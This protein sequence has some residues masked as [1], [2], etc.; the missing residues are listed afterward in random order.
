MGLPSIFRD[1]NA[2]A[3]LLFA[4]VL[5]FV[6]LDSIPLYTWDEARLAENAVEAAMDGHWFITH[7]EGKPDLWNT[8]PPLLIAVQAGLILV[9]G[10]TELAIR[11]PSA[12]AAV[13]LLF[14]VFRFVKA[15]SNSTV[16]AWLAAGMLCT[17]ALAMG[18]HNSRTGDY[19]ALL[20]LFLFLGAVRFY[21]YLNLERTTDLYISAL[22]FALAV[23]TKGIAGCLLFPSLAILLAI[24]GKL[25]QQLSKPS[26]Y[27]A[28]L[29]FLL[30]IA[31]Y[32][33]T[34][35]WAAPGYL[36][37]V[38]TNELGGRF[39][40]TLEGNEGSF[41]YYFEHLFNGRFGYW[42][43]FLLPSA[44][45]AL[46]KKP[47]DK[48]T[49]SGFLLALPFLLVISF[50][51]TKLEWY[52]LPALPFL[53]IS[54]SLILKEIID[55]ITR[56]NPAIPT[57]ALL[58]LLFTLPVQQVWNQNYRPR[59]SLGSEKEY[60]FS[61]SSTLKSALRGHFNIDGFVIVHDESYQQFI[62]YE[63]A[64]EQ[65][66]VHISKQSLEELQPG[67]KVLASMG[68]IKEELLRRFT[69]REILNHGHT[70][71]Y[72]LLEQKVFNN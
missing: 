66:G 40:S 60:Y 58:V 71:G 49:I 61:I 29:F 23:L 14:F 64:L 8:K 13:L 1:S 31:A 41:T 36:Q 56:I 43:I 70:M 26:V 18:H 38:W 39:A 46:Q 34:R 9:I 15:E 10:P 7:Y 65:K 51:K 54:A 3:L 53:A 33:L 72:L 19:D 35:E 32:Y 20:C 4:S 16:R 17:S 12:I 2:L 5:L 47:F 11:L 21:R 28:S 30:P 6:N 37:A 44:Y 63:K 42:W 50:S 25:R 52:D 69:T 24:S 45:I 59:A 55:S 68:H 62:F 57:Y 27:Y 22:F 67:D 48:L